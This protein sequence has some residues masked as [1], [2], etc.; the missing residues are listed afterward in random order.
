M[1]RHA[2]VAGLALALW[3]ITARG[4]E[5]ERALVA[6]ENQIARAVVE[7]DTAFVERLWDEDFVYTGVRGEVKSKADIL[8]ELRDGAL[9][10]DLL[11]FDDLRVRVYGDAAV[12]TGLAT[13]RGRSPAG[14]ISGEFRYTRVYA[15]RQGQWRL[16]AF[17]GTPIVRP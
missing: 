9:T 15:K 1:I 12:V 11:R 5:A 16:V 14:E 6:L 8:N 7:A 17:Q 13:T 2:C 4:D 10:F 3:T